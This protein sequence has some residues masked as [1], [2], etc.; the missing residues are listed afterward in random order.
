[1]RKLKQKKIEVLKV[2]TQVRILLGPRKG[3]VDTIKEVLTT[4]QNSPLYTLTG[5]TERLG[6]Q[7]F[8]VVEESKAKVVEQM[9]KEAHFKD[10]SQQPDNNVAQS[11]TTGNSSDKPMEKGG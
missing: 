6:Y 4:L 11:G 7:V 8:A 3:Q 9:A 10:F 1:M 5:D 2:G